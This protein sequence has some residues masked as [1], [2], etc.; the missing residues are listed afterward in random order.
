MDNLIKMCFNKVH[1]PSQ[2][3][4]MVEILLWLSNFYYENLLFEIYTYLYYV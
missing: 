2:D 3:L 1:S 4:F